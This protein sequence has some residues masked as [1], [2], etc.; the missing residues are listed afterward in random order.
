MP[1]FDAHLHAFQDD[2]TERASLDRINRAKEHWRA[3]VQG[4][5]ELE[6]TRNKMALRGQPPDPP[7]AGGLTGGGGTMPSRDRP[8]FVPFLCF[9]WSGDLLP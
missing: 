1:P 8:V 3:Y 7:M 2:R 4:S 6:L 5:A 9:G